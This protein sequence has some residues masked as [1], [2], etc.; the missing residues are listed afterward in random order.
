MR[1]FEKLR[2]LRAFEKQH[3]DFFSTVEDH[4][5]IGEIGYHQAKGKPLTLKQL[6]LLDVGSVAT[7]QRRLRRLKELGLVQHRRAANDRRAVELTLSPKCVRIFAKYDAL[8]SSKPAARDAARGN[9]EPRH[10][11]GLCDSDA[12][13]R[14][15]LVTFLAQGLKR[16]DKCILVAPAEA[17]K[18]ILAEL[19]H[20]RKAPEELVVSEG[21]NSADAQFAFLKRMSQG[22]KHAGQ[23]MCLAADM[24]WILSKNLRI[25]AVLDIETRVDA[26]ARQSSLTGL[27]VY[28]ARHSSSGDFLHA[29]KCHRDHS[30]YPI[31]LG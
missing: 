30:R 31:V 3:L 8:M 1:L 20:R 14:K 6:F 12:G 15:L 9:G 29:V 17:H 27:C 28:D 22:A 5:L 19:F 13:R 2:A 18:E 7:V 25:D 10:V 11:C 23:T 4:H 16:G 24:S 26:L 21:Y